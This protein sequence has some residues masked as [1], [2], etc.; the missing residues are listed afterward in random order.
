[1]DAKIKSLT[2][3]DGMKMKIS[4]AQ[5]GFAS[6]EGHFTG[7]EQSR[8]IHRI[9]I[10]PDCSARLGRSRPCSATSQ[11]SVDLH[12]DSTSAAGDCVPLE[13]ASTSELQLILKL[14]I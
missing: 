4:V 12:G 14:S 2:E 1:M 3:S 5:I 9:R 10:D 13:A 7:S 6:D 11:A 8:I